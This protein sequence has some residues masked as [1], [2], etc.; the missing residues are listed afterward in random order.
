MICMMLYC[1]P[2]IVLD[3]CQFYTVAHNCHRKINCSR[4]QI[5]FNGINTTLFHGTNTFSRH[6]HF[7]TAQTLFHGTNTFSRHK[8]FFRAQTLFHGINSFSRH[9]QFF[10][11]QTLFHGTNTFSWHKHFF[12]AQ[13]LFHG[14]NSFSRHK[15]FF[16]AQ[17]LFHGTNKLLFAAKYQSPISKFNTLI[18]SCSCPRCLGE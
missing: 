14:I 9:K 6:K 3:F 5:N 17:T 1:S 18:N 12:T 13:T 2:R 7:F 11:A 15:H 4:H 8:H 10:T 16:T